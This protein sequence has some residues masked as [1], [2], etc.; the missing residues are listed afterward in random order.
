MATD[1]RFY[2]QEKQIETFIMRIKK[3]EI[4]KENKKTILDF[5]RQ[6]FIDGLSSARILFY[7][8]KLLR[9]AE[10]LKKDFKDTTIEDVRNLVEKIEQQDWAAWTK[11]NF[12]TTL[13][14]FYKWLRNT[15]DYPKEVRWIKAS[16]KNVNHTL[17]EDLITEEEI[18]KMIEHAYHPR[19][20]ALISVLY[21][22]G[23]RIGELASLHLKNVKFDKYGG[24]LIV[25]GKTGARRVRIISSS[26]YLSTWIN[27]HPLKEK[28]D[29]PLWV[30]IG[31]KGK[32]EMIDYDAIRVLLRRVAQRTGIKKRVNPHNF[33]HSRA[34]YLAS[35]LTEAQMKE[36]LGWVQ[37]S[38]MAST[39]VHLSGRDVDKSLL[40]IY[41]LEDEE[42]EK[43]ETRLKPKR[44]FRCDRLNSSTN[45]FCANCGAVLD[46]ETAVEMEDEMKGT[47]DKLVQLLEDEDV[48]NLL[49]QKIKQM[50]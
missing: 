48:R 16:K 8:H 19:D 10:W 1:N 35:H 45:K 13:K 49:I 20:K 24:V 33:R 38:E 6:C 18:E 39:Y 31:T 25:N 7:L 26:Q 42:K 37:G 21:E 43:E 3:S 32:N 14:K 40:K 44:C 46:I 17:P 2:N 36:Y 29:A 28:T 23:C 30:G 12:K 9:L 15:E 41:G 50:S 4:S 11:L 27:N 5:K 47:D 22:S 34:T